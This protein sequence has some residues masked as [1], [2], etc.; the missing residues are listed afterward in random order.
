MTPAMVVAAGNQCEVR[1]I[2]EMHDGT[3]LSTRLPK[4]LWCA[5]DDFDG[6]NARRARTGR[7]RR[8][9][10][11]TRQRLDQHGLVAGEQA[12]ES[13][14]AFVD[15]SQGRRQQTAIPA[16]RIK[17]THLLPAPRHLARPK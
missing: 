10:D 6:A 14:R 17:D 7:R 8:P 15:V 16:V 11:L 5:I 9:V 13:Q 2:S 12:G 1:T 4:P 3:S